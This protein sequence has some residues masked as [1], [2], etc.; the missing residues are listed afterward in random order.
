MAGLHYQAVH[1]RELLNVSRTDV[2]RWLSTLPP[3]S[4]A[5]TQIRTARTFT[6]SDLAFFSIVALLHS[7]LDMPLR[8]I[9]S[10]SKEL[11]TML[12]APAASNTMSMRYFVSQNDDGA[13]HVD[14]EVGGAVSLAIDFVPIWRAVYEFV[15]LEPNPQSHLQFGLMALPS[16]S[17]V[18]PHNVRRAG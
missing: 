17:S 15:G 8:T 2:Q 12:S 3:F 13:W 4:T 16:R 9:A 10:F 5:P 7:R 14:T 1:I 6:I 18:E 11:H